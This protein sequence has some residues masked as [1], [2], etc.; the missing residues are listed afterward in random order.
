MYP[1]INKDANMLFTMISNIIKLLGIKLTN[2]CK[3][4]SEILYNFIER[5]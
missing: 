3:A 5:N 2:M 1:I 4:F